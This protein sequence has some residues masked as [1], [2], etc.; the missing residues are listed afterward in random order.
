MRRRVVDESPSFTVNELVARWGA[1]DGLEHWSPGDEDAA[2]AIIFGRGGFVER[3]YL[4]PVAG[5]GCVR[6]TELGRVYSELL[7]GAR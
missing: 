4:E 7:R 6:V 2:R 1:D 5:N 3:G